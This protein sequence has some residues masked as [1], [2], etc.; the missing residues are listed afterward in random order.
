MYV[1]NLF[2]KMLIILAG[3]F[4]RN[5]AKIIYEILK[6]FKVFNNLSPLNISCFENCLND[7]F[8]LYG[9]S[10]GGHGIITNNYL[11]LNVIDKLKILNNI[12]CIRSFTRNKNS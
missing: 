8:E 1:N 11:N 10:K 5:P 3:I 4:I 2:G 6:D 12:F 7:I 9:S